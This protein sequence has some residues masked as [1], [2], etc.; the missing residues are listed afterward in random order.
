[1]KAEA[2]YDLITKKT[3]E[4]IETLS[5]GIEFQ[6][7]RNI[8]KQ[9]EEVVRHLLVNKQYDIATAVK[10]K[11]QDAV[12]GLDITFDDSDLRY[13]VSS[14]KSNLK[15]DIIEVQRAKLREKIHF[16]TEAYDNNILT[17]GKARATLEAI[18]NGSTEKTVK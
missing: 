10:A 5:Q 1:M 11:A 7:K 9:V 18:L 12:Y 15:E 4:Y 3:E 14:I 13:I 16:I 8:D 2:L 17:V 6:V